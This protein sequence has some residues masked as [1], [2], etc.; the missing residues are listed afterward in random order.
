MGTL[1][2]LEKSKEILLYIY[3]AFTDPQE[4]QLIENL[5]YMC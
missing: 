2:Q 1:K 5:L 3:L 4:S